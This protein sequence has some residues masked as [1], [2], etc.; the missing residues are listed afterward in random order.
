MGEG[1]PDG[2][3]STCFESHVNRQEEFPITLNQLRQK[4]K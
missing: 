4:L 2:L 1:T 3:D